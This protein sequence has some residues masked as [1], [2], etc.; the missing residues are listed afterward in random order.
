MKAVDVRSEAAVRLPPEFLDVDGREVAEHFAH[1]VYAYLRSPY[2]D[3][4]VYNSVVQY[5]TTENIPPPAVL[6]QSRR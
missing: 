1:E 3:L 4:S 6:D 5:D 2:R